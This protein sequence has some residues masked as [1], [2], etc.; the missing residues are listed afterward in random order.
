MNSE[1]FPKVPVLQVLGAHILW[2]QKN[3]LPMMPKGTNSH[4][5]V[6]GTEDTAR[7]LMESLTLF[8]VLLRQHT[9]TQ[10]KSRPKPWSTIISITQLSF[11]QP[12]QSWGTISSVVIIP[13]ISGLT[14]KE[15]PGISLICCSIRRELSVLPALVLE[16]VETAIFVSQPLTATKM[17][18]LQWQD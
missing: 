2:F 9:A 3:V 8:S 6:C 12:F 13:R 17:L 10:E 11:A 18:P 15:T 1:V 14:V 5:T 16:D 4:S 7:N